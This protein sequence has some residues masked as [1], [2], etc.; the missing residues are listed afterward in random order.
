[1]K[2]IEVFAYESSLVVSS[3][4]GGRIEDRRSTDWIHARNGEPF[5]TPEAACQGAIDCIAD[6]I[7]HGWTRIDSPNCV[8]GGI[9]YKTDETGDTLS[10]KVEEPVRVIQMFLFL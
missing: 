4:N 10:F 5:T 8:G 2:K 9:F 3:R 7:E 6:K 1:M